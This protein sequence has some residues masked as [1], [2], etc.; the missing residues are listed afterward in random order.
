MPNGDFVLTLANSDDP[1]GDALS[2]TFAIYADAE[3]TDLVWYRRDVSEGEGETSIRVTEAL[4]P[5]ATYHWRA[6][7]VDDRGS[8]SAPSDMSTFAVSVTSSGESSSGCAVTPGS[9]STAWP[10]LLLAL[11]ALALPRRRR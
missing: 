6:T 4:D 3:A 5:G 11:L 1:D 9:G 7:A 2:Y 8:S 10:P